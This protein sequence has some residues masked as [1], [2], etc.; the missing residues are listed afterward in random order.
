MNHFSD[1]YA[2]F[3]GG[4]L[5]YGWGRGGGRVQRRAIRSIRPLVLHRRGR[6][7]G[8]SG[9]GIVAMVSVAM[10]GTEKV[11]DMNADSYTA[12]KEMN[13]KR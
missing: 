4:Y 1:A 12:D 6:G 5:G 11:E 3:S 7:N 13:S 8:I 10:D 9:Y 2:P